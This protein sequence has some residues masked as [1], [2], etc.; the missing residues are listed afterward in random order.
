MSPR[1]RRNCF[2]QSAPRQ[3]KVASADAPRPRGF[4]DISIVQGTTEIDSSSIRTLR[5]NIQNEMTR[6]NEGDRT[7]IKQRGIFK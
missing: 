1:E 7:D 3:I 6:D 2:H 5:Q 4:N